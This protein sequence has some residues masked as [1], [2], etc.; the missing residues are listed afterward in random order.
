MKGYRNFII[1][2]LSLFIIYVIAELN[3]PKPVDWTVTL[4][5]NDKNPYGGYIVY[6]Q[7]K[8]LFP[9]VPMRSYYLPVYNQLNNLREK[10]TA[11]MILTPS[12]DL[13]NYDYREMINY[14]LQGNYVVVSAENFGDLFL[15][16][17]KLKTN[18]R[19]SIHNRDSAAINFVNPLLRSGKAFTFLSFT[20][21]QYFS[22]LDT[23]KTTVLGVN[24]RNQP[25]FIKIAYGKGALLIHAAPICFS[26]YFMLFANNATYTATAL[27]YV[28]VNISKIYWDEYYKLSKEA[29]ST[30]LRFFLKN[31][32]LRR[33]LYLALAGLIIYVL[34]QIK[35]RQRIIPVTAP[36][37]N[38]SLD[39]I[40]TVSGVYFN[41]KDNNSI[42]HKKLSYFL[43]F[44]RHRFYLPSHEID[45]HFIEQ[46]ARKSGVPVPQITEL[47]NLLN[48]IETKNDV[49]DDLLLMI[50]QHI[51][52]FYKQL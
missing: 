17:L 34:F 50:D 16:S 9:G 44:V 24:D 1:I 21:D 36:L 37:K 10:N 26:N 33:A 52:N 28:P 27:S 38:N 49:T 18:K 14:V 48:Y 42:A 8:D 2:F 7:L 6:H 4:N 25:N 32:H 15:D 29:S 12:F 46:L 35:R 30:P 39:F 13:T 11:Y 19:F 47:F 23:A 3:K 5:K 31:D 43:D 22:R 45:Q 51:D 20:M 41:Q 40:K